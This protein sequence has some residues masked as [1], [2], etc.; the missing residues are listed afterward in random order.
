[1]LSL[2]VVQK[3]LTCLLF[4]IANLYPHAN[5][6]VESSLDLAEDTL[7]CLLSIRSVSVSGTLGTVLSRASRAC[8]AVRAHLVG[9]LGNVGTASLAGNGVGLKVALA[10]G[11]C[12]VTVGT[13]GVGLE[14]TVGVGVSSASGAETVA[15]GEL[16]VGGGELLMSA[17]E[18]NDNDMDIQQT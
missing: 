12:A 7:G 5:H 11:Q 13:G 4:S 2:L 6:L 3:L 18:D 10:T 15:V 16:L 9:V 1:V 14:A 8:S 17:Y